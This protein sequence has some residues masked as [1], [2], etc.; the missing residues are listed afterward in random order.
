MVVAYL[1]VGLWRQRR[2]GRHRSGPNLIAESRS[3]VLPPLTPEVALDRIPELLGEI[4]RLLAV[5]WRA[6]DARRYYDDDE[7][8]RAV[9]YFGEPIQSGYV[10]IKQDTSPM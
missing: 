2:R 1:A 5:L 8:D 10:L 4:E 9:V 7:G 6:T 3:L